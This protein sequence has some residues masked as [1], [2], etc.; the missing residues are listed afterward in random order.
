MS[1]NVFLLLSPGRLHLGFNDCLERNRYTVTLRSHLKRNS[2]V[3]DGA[4][5]TDLHDIGIAGSRRDLHE[6]AD[7]FAALPWILQRTIDA[8]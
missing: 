6:P 8:G 4:D 1:I 3:I 2:G 5:T 7:V